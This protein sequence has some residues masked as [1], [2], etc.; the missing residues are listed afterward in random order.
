MQPTNY[1]YDVIGNLTTV[2]QG[3][4]TRTFTYD[5]LARL[6]QATNPE[7][8]TVNYQYDDNGNL[9]VKTDARTV[10]TH[11]EYDALNRLTRRWYNGSNAVSSTTHNSPALP[12]GVGATDEARFKYDAAL[13]TTGAPI[14]TIG[15]AKGR[16]VAQ[17]YGTGT[18]GDYYAYDALGRVTLK[19]QQTGSVKYQM[20]ASYNLA[21]AIS[22]LT[23][24]SGHSVTNT[25]DQAGRLAALSGSL[26][27][28]AT[29]T[30]ATGILYAPTGGLVKEQFGTTTPVYNKLAYNSR[31][32]L[33]EIRTS[34]SYTGPTD[35]DWNRGA[36]INSYSEQCTGICAGSSMTDNNGNLRKQEVYI[37]ND[38]Q[39]SSHT[40]RRQQYDYDSLNRL[41]WVRE[42]LNGAEQWRQWFKYDRWGNRTIDTTIENGQSRTYG[43]GINSKA[44]TVNTSNNRL[45]VPGGQSGVMAYD[46]AGNLTNDTYTG[47]GNRTY[48]AENKITSAWGGN[49][50]AQTYKYDAS[51]QR[52]RRTVDSVE[53]WQVYGLGGELLAEYAANAAAGSPQ[54][55]YGYR[56][57]QLLITAEAP[58]VTNVASAA[59]G[60]VASASSTISP[61]VASNAINGDHVG[62]ASCWA[63][64]TSFGYPDW[65]QVEFAGSKTISEIDVFG[66]QQNHSNPVEPTATMTSSYA[67]TNF[68]VQYW[69]GS[70]WATV[71]GGSITGNDKV[72]R[73]FTFAPLITSK[74]RVHVTNVA[75]DNRS[76]VVE[77]EAYGSANLAS[78]AN[79][80]VATASSTI[81]PFVAS[82]AINGDH[83]G[84]ASCWADD[85]SFGY[86]DWIQ[87]EF[88][89][90]KTISEIDVFGL[91]QN[92][93]NPVEPTATMTSSYA[94][95]NFE[96]QYWTGSAW[97]TVP[98]ADV[99]GNDKVWRKFTFAPLSTSKIRVYVTS[100]VGDNRSQ[101]VEIEAYTGSTSATINWL[102]TDHLGT[103][104]MLIDQTGNLANVKRHDYLPFGEELL[105]PS[106]GRTT[107]QGYASG[108]GVRQQFTAKERDNET[109]LDYFN[110]RYYAS[111]L[112][113]FTSP[114]P[115]TA[116]AVSANPQTFNRYSYVTNSP[117]NIIDPTGMFGIPL[118]DD[119]T[120]QQQQPSTPQ[121]A[122]PLPKAPAQDPQV[123]SE[124]TA[125]ADDPKPYGNLPL[126][127]NY[128]FSGMGSLIE[129]TVKDQNGDP[130]SNVTVT[131]A[132]TP[133]TT[134]QNSSPVT[135]DDGKI[136]DLVGRGSFGPQLTNEQARAVARDVRNTGN[137]IVQDH[138][139][140][141]VSSS[142]RA[143]VATHQRIFSNV[144]ANGNLRP[145]VSIN[146][147]STNYTIKLTEIKLT[148]I[149]PLICPRVVR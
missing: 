141:I 139:M 120:E 138:V 146:N 124:V 109:G 27:D 128:Y 122:Q 36:I 66:L 61:F 19:I 125:K 17:T 68:E 70:A 114:D 41:N 63:D 4:Q 10:S 11:F 51:G 142:G 55:E 6:R 131:E 57:G 108:D 47:A 118:S 143:A 3:S 52:I 60:A 132:V 97:A 99:T 91:Q 96:V 32:Q 28:G 16:L 75:G 129:F 86:P 50:Q 92:H 106:G 13:T 126:G 69:T 2:T 79:G 34:T 102:V 9:L 8:G 23:Y 31:G 98:G 137:H 18:N 48:D 100:V 136:V 116:S 78:A 123:P 105:A 56:N 30:Y 71:P 104:R 111:A 20:S 67:L 103:P 12:A 14:Y 45:G 117:L 93:S 1:A 22:V 54:K 94:L 85:T 145:V 21:G 72:W 42:V 35:V 144:D 87:V 121:P 112:G 133:A 58:S 119:S 25:F 82:N 49:N 110:A 53:T 40:M 148:P 88:A 65:I 81:S 107:A 113:R 29:R 37:P 76:Q 90:S 33:A 59:N 26:G 115:L 38:D 130:M 147:Y 140:V 84:N 74:I 134:V 135:R 89:G 64:D 73:K 39:L 7:S 101:V 80:A 5:S 149:Q 46:A 43:I 44:F 15:S 62:S 77:I 24:P 83:V 95:T 127:P